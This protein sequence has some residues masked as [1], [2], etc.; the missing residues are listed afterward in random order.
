MEGQEVAESE[1]R[2]RL[3]HGRQ[4]WNGNLPFWPEIA[5]ND[6]DPPSIS[7]LAD[8]HEAS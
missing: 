1:R 8:Q 5:P 3:I 7:T 6:D 2:K 4:D